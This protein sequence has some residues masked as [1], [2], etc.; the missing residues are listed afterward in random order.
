MT[1]DPKRVSIDS[2]VVGYANKPYPDDPPPQYEPVQAEDPP[3]AVTHEPLTPFDGD[4][5]AQTTTETPK[6]PAG[7]LKVTFLCFVWSLPWISSLALSWGAL[8]RVSWSDAPD[9]VYVCSCVRLR[10]W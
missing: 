4:P 8:S 7:P 5:E 10:M 2:A 9:A 1:T 3:D 6:K